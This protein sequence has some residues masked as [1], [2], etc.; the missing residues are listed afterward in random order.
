M[1]K[2]LPKGL[3]SAEAGTAKSSVYNWAIVAVILDKVA[4][5][6]INLQGGWV[7]T[8]LIIVFLAALS[9]ISKLTVGN[10]PPEDAEIVRR[11]IEE[12]RADELLEEGRN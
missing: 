7:Q 11:K 2:A 10:I 9:Y 3:S 8:A 4:D 1:P 6:I 5:H 12:M